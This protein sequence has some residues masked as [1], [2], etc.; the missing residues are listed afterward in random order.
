MGVRPPTDDVDEEPDVIE[1]GI[2]ALDARL[3]DA[4]IEFP[5][6]AEALA[7]QYGQTEIPYDAA[8][9]AMTLGN[10]LAE[11][12]ETEFESE[13]ALLNALHP[14]FEQ[15]RE[16]ASTSILAQLRALVPF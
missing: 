13:Q 16:S 12:T 9:N 6:T 1:F 7:S 4:E 11:T 10:A 14:I 2:A 8:G 15:K 3:E 5:V